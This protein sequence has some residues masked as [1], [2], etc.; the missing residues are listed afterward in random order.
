MS[1]TASQVSING[2][3]LTRTPTPVNMHTVL[4]RWPSSS[5]RQCRW[6]CR[7]SG[8][9]HPHR[10]RTV[11]AQA[12][13]LPEPTQRTRPLRVRVGVRDSAW[14]PERPCVTAVV[15][16]ARLHGCEKRNHF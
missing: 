11:V 1:R 6:H 7:L 14:Q 16:K 15:A 12:H 10:G 5:S 3:V 9:L 13:C 8:Q 2:Y 4:C